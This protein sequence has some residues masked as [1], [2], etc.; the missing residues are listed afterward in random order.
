MKDIIKGMIIGIG[1]IIP[2]V[3]G[4]VLAISLGVYERAVNAALN[5]FKSKKNVYYLFRL[6]IGVLFSMIFMSKIIIYFLDNYYS[7]T[8]FLFVGFI[9]GSMKEITNNIKKNYFHFTFISFIIIFLLGLVTTNKEIVIENSFLSFAYYFISGIVDMVA[10][11][12]P[13]ISGTALLMLIG[14]YD[15]VMLL[16][17]NLL[18]FDL[19]FS[20]IRT[21]I[22]FF[23]GLLL[24]LIGSLK[25]VDFLF[26]KYYHQTY[27]VILG[28]L[29]GSI[30]IMLKTCEFTFLSTIIG[31]GITVISYIVIKKI[32][33]LFD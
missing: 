23:I 18:N 13:G 5:V 14:S 3:S 25:L 24:G 32:N 1:K 33:L 21:V 10:T 9:L 16:F 11:I 29:L 19:F 27:N 17:S 22:P 15:K 30:F 26:K 8:I 28:L 12:I 2:G 31:L 7:Y 4:S 6:F 20:N